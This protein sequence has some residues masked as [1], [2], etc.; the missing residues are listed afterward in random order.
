MK[1]ITIETIKTLMDRIEKHESWAE[2]DK[3]FQVV[4]G[5][6]MLESPEELNSFSRMLLT[7]TKLSFVYKDKG[8]LNKWFQSRN[9]GYECL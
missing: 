4:F 5:R 2:I 8:M 7:M 1:K 3:D 6:T 9:L